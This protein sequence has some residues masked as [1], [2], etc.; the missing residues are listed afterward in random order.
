MSFVLVN[1]RYVRVFQQ[2][3]FDRE[4]PGEDQRAMACHAQVFAFVENSGYSHHRL[5]IHT[6]ARAGN[7][8]LDSALHR[9]IKDALDPE[10]LICPGRYF[11][12]SGAGSSP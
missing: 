11:I 7:I 9:K 5:D 1:D 2:L 8:M 3:V 4:K 12:R 6:M 10:G